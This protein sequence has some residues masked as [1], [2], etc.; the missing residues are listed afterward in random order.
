MSDILSRLDWE[1]LSTRVRAQQRSREKETPVISVYR[2]WARRS[3]ALV[4]AILEASTPINPRGRL[5]VSDPFSGGGT[6]AVEALR[7]GHL[8]YAQDINPWATNGLA[9]ALDGVPADSLQAAAERL[10]AAL[11]SLRGSEYGAQCKTHGVA[12]TLYAF[13]VTSAKCRS[14]HD[15]FYLFPYSLITRRSRSAHE[16]H[17]YFGCTYCGVVSLRPLNA[18]KRFCRQCRHALA[19]PARPLLDG[20]QA[21]CPRCLTCKPI[22]ALQSRSRHLI[23]VQRLCGSGQRKLR[24]FDL[25]TL[26]EGKIS[27][28]NMG[29]LAPLAD[30]IPEGQETR[31]LRQWGFRRWIDLY[32]PRQLRCLA[33]ALRKIE[34][35]RLPTPIRRRLR[36]AVVGSTE[37]AG[38]LC[39]WDRFYP[40]PFEAMANHRFSPV[41][42]SVEVNLLS[43]VGRGTIPRRLSASV[44][45]A[46]WAR[47]RIPA[48]LVPTTTSTNRRR[49]ESK[50]PGRMLLVTG[51]STRQ[52][53]PDNVADLV[54][55]DPPYYDSVQYGELSLLFN[56]WACAAKLPA[57]RYALDLKRE[58]VPN[59]IRGTGHRE[60]G[61]LLSR[62]FREVR[63]SLAPGGRLIL[64]FHSTE[65]KAWHSLGRSLLHS[66]LTVTSLAV[67]QSENET[68]HP[69][70]GKRA[71]SKDLIIE[72]RPGAPPED[73]I[74]V[75][76]VVDPEDR[77]LVAAG[78]AMAKKAGKPLQQMRNLYLQ[79][80]GSTERRIR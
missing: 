10:L 3:H 69:K 76:R 74:V 17:G 58:A 11:R 22:S 15:R 52:L 27:A 63:R 24:H 67:C 33:E 45:A 39:R 46:K 41:G 72:C 77:E 40:K 2:W 57:A 6:V 23:L 38:Y 80:A 7:R 36:M 19:D 31:V 53:I 51:S 5:V 32:P 71:F 56:R 79:Q 37:M 78:L 43:S 61:R 12:E 66:G 75:T 29:E 60:Y 42:L 48:D 47:E 25:P 68:D 14:C 55:T 73:P 30:E 1:T 70:R 49:R 59:R 9:T 65:L 64:T 26:E 16:T 34:T 4:G 35:L 28:L 50:M 21:R 62:I 13:W 8:V 44:A 20:R 18:R 54:L